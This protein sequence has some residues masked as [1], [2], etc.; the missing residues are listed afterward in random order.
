[1]TFNPQ[2]NLIYIPASIINSRFGP[3]FSR[4]VGQPRSGTLTAIDPTTNKIAW[5][6][7]TKFPLGTGSGLLSTASGLIFHGESDGNIVAYDI[8]NGD[9]LWSFQTGAGADAPVATYE[10]NGEQYVAILAGGNSFQLS[11]RGDNLW[12]FK[13]GGTVKP[14]PAPPEPPTMQPTGER[15]GGNR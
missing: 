12:A 2:T 13:L 8:K 9:V 11:K 14:L 5:Q 7:R 15:R 4:P 1:M 6:K 10:V 3:T